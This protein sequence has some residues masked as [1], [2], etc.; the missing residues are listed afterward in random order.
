MDAYLYRSAVCEE[1]EQRIE[2]LWTHR[3]CDDGF[4]HEPGCYPFAGRSAPVYDTAR[5]GIPAAG[6]LPS[7]LPAVP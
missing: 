5:I 2:M 6:V 7:M 4:A 1:V 3:Q